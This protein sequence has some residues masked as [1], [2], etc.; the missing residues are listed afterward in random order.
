MSIFVVFVMLVIVVLVW[1]QV[2]PLGKG[3]T[4][5]AKAAK[6]M[7]VSIVVGVVL[8]VAGAIAAYTQRGYVA[9]G[10]EFGA[11]LIPF[12]VYCVYAMRASND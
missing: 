10:G 9:A 4:M 3:A 1:R 11:L 7:A 2:R 8:F 5:A 12:F 6:I